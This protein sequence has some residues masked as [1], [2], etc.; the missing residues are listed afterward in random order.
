MS[1]GQPPD[2]FWRLTFR[3]IDFVFRGYVEAARTE[4]NERLSLAW[5]IEAF[6]RRKTLP[7]LRDILDHGPRKRMS[8]E[9]V[10]A[11]TRSWLSD[12]AAI[13]RHNQKIK[14]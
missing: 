2:L 10:E 8:A 13:R 11:V 9:R 5:Y 3:E 6:R 1:I 4:R 7:R 14:G 12:A